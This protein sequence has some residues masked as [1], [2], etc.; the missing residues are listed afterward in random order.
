MAKQQKSQ[1]G[2]IQK[3]VKEAQATVAAAHLI[4]RFLLMSPQLLL[5]LAS[6]RTSTIRFSSAEI[7]A[8][9]TNVFTM[10]APA[11]PSGHSQGTQGSQ[12]S[13]GRSPG[14]PPQGG[15]AREGPPAPP[16]HQDPRNFGNQ[17]VNGDGALGNVNQEPARNEADFR[18]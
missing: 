5:F 17:S 16:P 8:H 13:Q 9:A 18:L 14:N 1:S 7:H 6:S 3:R 4:N 10:T 12:G 11:Q 2:G 15:A